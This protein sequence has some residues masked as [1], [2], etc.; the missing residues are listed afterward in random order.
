V[1]PG[2]DA[3]FDHVYARPPERLEQQRRSAR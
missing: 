1:Q 2:V 3:V